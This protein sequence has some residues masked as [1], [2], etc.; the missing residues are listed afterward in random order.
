VFAVALAVL[1]DPD[2]AEDVLWVDALMVI[3]PDVRAIV[4]LGV[5]GGLTHAAIAEQLGVPPGTVR[6]KY[7]RGL[8]RL[9]EAV[10]TERVV[11]SLQRE[12]EAGT[13]EV[14]ARVRRTVRA[15]RIA[16]DQLAALDR[17]PSSHSRLGRELRL[18]LPTSIVDRAA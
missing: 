16:T 7:R 18:D 15:R 3:A 1:R 11:T 17:P 5:L 13:R 12:L 8:R 10:L 6:W 9:E 14:S 4:A 2:A